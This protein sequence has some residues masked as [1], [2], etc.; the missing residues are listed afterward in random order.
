MKLPFMLLSFLLLCQ[1]LIGAQVD[2][3]EVYSN[4]MQKNIKAVVVQPTNKL[5]SKLPTL[6][7]LH[8]FSGKYHD[9]IQRVAQLQDL[10]DRY[11]ILVVC[12]DGGYSS[13]YWDIDGDKDFQ[14]ETF[15]SNELVSYISANY[16]ANEE[17]RYR[18]ITGFSMGGHGALYLA[19][20][21]QDVYGAVGSIA[22]G[23]DIRPFPNNWDMAKRLG[24][25]VENSA[26]WQS[27]TIMEM[28]HLAGGKPLP[29]YIDCGRDDFFHE[30]NLR[31]HERMTYLNIPHHYQSMP[32]KHDWAYVSKSL[33]YQFAFFHQF[34]VDSER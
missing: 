5:N 6:Y 15:V 1:Q 2:T 25:Y 31:L 7:L 10:V 17:S 33:D 24:S 16:P 28:L 19:L 27:H 13:W 22:G 29:I 12:P 34:F 14:Y 3:V 20:R 30:V 4:S 26:S 23:V 18:A 21:H 9:Y 32:G 8:G 11:Q